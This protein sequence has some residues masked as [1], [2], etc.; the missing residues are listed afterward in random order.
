MEFWVFLRIGFEGLFVVGFW[1]E[2]VWEWGLMEDIFW[3]GLVV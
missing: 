1:G 3:E 2:V